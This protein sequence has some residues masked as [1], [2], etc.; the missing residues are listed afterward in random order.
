MKKCKGLCGSNNLIMIRD[1]FDM[2]NYFP[3]VIYYQTLLSE[4]IKASDE[5]Y[6]NT[7]VK[8]NFIIT[9]K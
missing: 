5:I 1:I 2:S 3:I 8:A 4:I 9:K 6:K 7:K